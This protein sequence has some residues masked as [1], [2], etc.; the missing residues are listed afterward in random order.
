MNNLHYRINSLRWNYQERNLLLQFERFN[1]R[2]KLYGKYNSAKFANFVYICITR[3]KVTILELKL[4]GQT[5]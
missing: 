3:K 1:G 5:W 4:V 2:D